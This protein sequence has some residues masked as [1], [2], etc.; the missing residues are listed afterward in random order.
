MDA[1]L[2]TSQRRIGLLLVWARLSEA[3]IADAELKCQD[4]AFE[5]PKANKEFVKKIPVVIFFFFLLK[6][7]YRNKEFPLRPY[8]SLIHGQKWSQIIASLYSN[9]FFY[10][11]CAILWQFAKITQNIYLHLSKNMN[12]ESEKSPTQ[13]T[14]ICYDSI[15]KRMV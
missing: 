1:H 13:F 3:D 12:E 10:F 8:I 5:L 15:K 14:K 9:I 4:N 2:Y 6:G 11:G 7:G